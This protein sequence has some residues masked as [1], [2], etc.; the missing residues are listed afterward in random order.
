MDEGA[1]RKL[2]SP[3]LLRGS[4]YARGGSEGGSCLEV[5]RLLEPPRAG[6]CCLRRGQNGTGR[7]SGLSLG[8]GI[9]EPC[10]GADVALETQR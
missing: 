3:R 5:P 8:R 6:G 10:L 7:A 1:L 9:P 2:V 4:G